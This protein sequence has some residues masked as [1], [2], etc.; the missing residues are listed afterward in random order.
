MVRYWGIFPEHIGTVAIAAFLHDALALGL[1]YLIARSFRLDEGSTRAMTFEVGIRNAG[2]GLLFVFTFFGGLGG[3][4][5]VA[6]WWGVW[7]IIAGL[8]LAVLWARR[9]D[10]RPAAVEARS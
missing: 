6:A 8:V 5:V 1:G 7:D 10:S 9:G 4:A 3:M 2:L